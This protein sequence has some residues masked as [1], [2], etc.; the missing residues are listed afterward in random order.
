MLAHFQPHRYPDR[1]P[2]DTPAEIEAVL[3]RALARDPAARYASAGALAADLRALAAPPAALD[4]RAVQ[5][6]RQAARDRQIAQWRQAALAAQAANQPDAARAAARQWLE[7]DPNSAEAQTV[8]RRL[9]SAESRVVPP[10]PTL[11]GD[12]GDGARRVEKNDAQGSP[13]DQATQ[14]GLRAPRPIAI[15]SA[16]WLAGCIASISLA[17]LLEGNQTSANAGT[18]IGWAAGWAGAGLLAGWRLRQGGRK[19]GRWQILWLVAGWPLCMTIAL[20]LAVSTYGAQPNT[21]IAELALGAGVA[22]A[23]AGV[24]IRAL[25]HK[26]TVGQLVLLALGWA[27]GWLLAEAGLNDGSGGGPW[28]GVLYKLSNGGNFHLVF[29][30]YSQLNVVVLAIAGMLG[31]ALGAG[32]LWLF[33]RLAMQPVQPGNAF[34]PAESRGGSARGDA[35]QWLEPAPGDAD[36]QML[37]PRLDETAERAG[38]AVREHTDTGDGQATSQKE[39]Q[40]PSDQEA[41]QPAF[42]QDTLVTPNTRSL[43][44]LTTIGVALGFVVAAYTGQSWHLA[45][46]INSA[47]GATIAALI[48]ALALRRIVYLGV[49]G[50]VTIVAGWAVPAAISGWL[51]EAYINSYVAA[52]I[53]GAIG[54]LATI[55]AVQARVSLRNNQI[56]LVSAGWAVGFLVGTLIAINIGSQIGSVSN[57]VGLALA[58]LGGAIAGAIGSAVMARQIGRARRQA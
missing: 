43:I 51:D 52:M 37:L 5:A 12:R 36:A 15:I 44:A 27:G 19:A 31:A 48:M 6:Q 9:D 24:A 20:F 32:L 25:G 57:P 41:A 58:A 50:Y 55:S 1:W 53:A 45:T 49:R 16:G 22:G 8:R 10:Q 34:V 7:L 17:W 29:S 3:E 54:G 28:H 42:D 4:E 30:T 23:I 18:L 26:L 33:G 11:V 56:L 35:R 47:L 39:R 2:D 13:I 40:A 38:R 21:A 46:P 14:V